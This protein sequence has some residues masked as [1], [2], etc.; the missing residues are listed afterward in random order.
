MSICSLHS[1]LELTNDN[2]YTPQLTELVCFITLSV[3]FIE[4]VAWSYI[5]FALDF[6]SIKKYII[7]N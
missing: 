5:K 7:V 6:S 4:G 1:I 3:Q 2:L